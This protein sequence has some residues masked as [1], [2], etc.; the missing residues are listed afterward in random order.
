MCSSNLTILW[1][2]IYLLPGHS[3]V[4]RGA[5]ASLASDPDRAA[6]R[7][8]AKVQKRHHFPLPSLAPPC[9]LSSARLDLHLWICICSRRRAVRREAPAASGTTASSG[10]GFLVVGSGGWGASSGA[11]LGINSSEVGAAMVGGFVRL[12]RLE[13]RIFWVGRPGEESREVNLRR[14]LANRSGRGRWP[15]SATEHQQRGDVSFFD[16]ALF[17]SVLLLI[18]RVASGSRRAWCH[19]RFLVTVV[20]IFSSSGGVQSSRAVLF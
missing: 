19:F 17:S 18:R 8:R 11:G 13:N 16:L 7:K 20:L 14:G 2:K 9:L 12:G 6:W 4:L 15:C 3:R 5:P 1:R 10:W